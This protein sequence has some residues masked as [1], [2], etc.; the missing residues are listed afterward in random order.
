MRKTAP[1]RDARRTVSTPSRRSRYV[2]S[3][4]EKITSSNHTDVL[5]TALK[6][7]PIAKPR[8]TCSTVSAF[9][10]TVFAHFIKNRLVKSRA[11]GAS[12]ITSSNHTDGVC[13]MRKTAP[14]RDARRTV[15]TPS[16]RSRYV[17]SSDEKIPSSNLTNVGEPPLAS[18]R[19]PYL[20][21]IERGR[22]GRPRPPA[23]QANYSYLTEE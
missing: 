9:R 13:E 17:F 19:C 21:L 5:R 3:S 6:T 20:L 23:N 1:A 14:A 8:R 2:F 15:S 18:R 22:G 7:R 11:R 10:R 4:D 12:K 16:R